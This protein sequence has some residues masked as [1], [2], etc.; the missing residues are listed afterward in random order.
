MELVR[1]AVEFVRENPGC[2]GREMLTAIGCEYD[3]E[4]KRKWIIDKLDGFVI[5]KGR[6]AATVY[7][8][9]KGNHQHTPKAR[10]EALQDRKKVSEERPKLINDIAQKALALIGASPGITSAELGVELRKDWPASSSQ[11]RHD[12]YKMLKIKGLV[13]AEQVG[14]SVGRKY[15]PL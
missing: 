11:H 9:R 3:D 4:T 1:M 5:K 10:A 14:T 15:F 12:A 8:P 13:R 7:Y 6:A 2:G